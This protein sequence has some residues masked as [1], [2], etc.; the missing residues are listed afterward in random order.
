VGYQYAKSKGAFVYTTTSTR[1]VEWVKA[2]GADRVI[3]YKTEDYKNIVSDV[4]IVFDTLGKQYTEEAFQLIKSDGRVVSIAG[5]MD[6]EMAKWLGMTNYKLPE[7]I[8]QVIEQSGGHY[9]FVFME[10]NGA[11]LAE[12]KSLIE[13]EKIKPVIDKVYPFDQSVEA[14]KHL[15]SGRAKGKIII[16]IS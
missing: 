4:D 7:K 3:D 14:F 6:E 5:P 1:N 15:A 8:A 10:P 2:L 13:D 12:I 11:H 16:K 9:K